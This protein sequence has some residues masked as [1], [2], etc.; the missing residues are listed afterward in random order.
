MRRYGVWAGNP[1][2]RPQMPDTCI[3]EVHRRGGAA[4]GMVG[5]Q[6]SRKNGHGPDGDWCKQHAKAAQAAWDEG[7][8][9][10]FLKWNAGSLL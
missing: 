8:Y 3:K 2:G 9:G 1:R 4:Y 5:E 7:R 10:D 6:C